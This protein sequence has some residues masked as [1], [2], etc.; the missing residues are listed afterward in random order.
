LGG[1][2]LRS[3]K[4]TL[5]L[6]TK[7]IQADVRLNN[8]DVVKDDMA[9]IFAVNHFTRLE[10]IL[11]PYFLYKQFGTEVWSLA[12][13]ELFEGR[14][15]KFLLSTGNVSTRDP[16]RD[17]VIIHS[18]LKGEHP[19]IIFPEGAM[20]KDKKVIDHRGEFR[21]YNNGKRR[22][23]HTGAA[24]LALRAEFYR[25]KLACF[26]N[27]P[28]H[29]GDREAVLERFNLESL[30]EV[31]AKR[32]VIVPVNV[33][34]FPIRARENVFLRMARG[35]AK[36]DLSP[37]A[38][39][40][41]SV[42]GTLIA[43]D[44]DIDVTFGDPIDVRDHLFTRETSELLA[45][46][47]HDMDALEADAGSLFN[48][49]ARTLMMRYMRDI[50]DLTTVNYDHIFGTILRYQRQRRFTERSYRNR[51][52]LAA[53][54]LA[55]TGKYEMHDLL[56]KNYREIIYEDM[57]PKFH[58]FMGVCLREGIV[59]ADGDHYVKNF[60]HRKSTADFH[61]S[62][63]EALSNVIANEIEPLADLAASIKHVAHMPREALSR[64][65]RE[66]FLEEDAIAF[67][68]DYKAFARPGESKPMDV[69]RPFLL[70]P[71]RVKGGILLVHGYMAAPLEIRAMAD[72]FFDHGYAVYGVRLK[73]HGTAPEDLAQT[74][75]TEWYE[76]LNRGYAVIKSVTD[77]ITIGGFSTG[78]VLALLAAARKGSKVQAAFSICAPL[79]L[80]NYMARHASSVVRMNAVLS[81]LGRNPK[82][83]IEN[84][85]ENDHI[86]YRRNPI[87]G[88]R[89][90]GEA[91]KA[92]EAELGNVH[93][94][95]LIVQSHKDPVVDPISG[96]TIFDK[97]G[98]E[99]KELTV[100]NRSNHGIINGEG[101]EEV[102]DRVHRFLHWARAKHRQP[103]LL[104][105]TQAAEAS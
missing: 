35:I 30:E 6:A 25:Q 76:S 95:S 68:Q 97:L 28:N 10:T 52:F 33:T 21:V 56:E 27:D 96:P 14:I 11:L 45:C 20:I 4:W 104:E 34:Y 87:V 16:D 7:L 40:E 1:F 62:R 58:D 5:E 57:S 72:Y 24:V 26:H 8:A 53:H 83:F 22:P 3:T 9:I 64:R 69:G 99:D 80:R 15:G 73:G 65:I 47:D 79:Q 29:D 100:F 39:E 81:K 86:N 82:E 38:V 23:P 42:E 17:K 88:V 77:F 94:P 12:A 75:W 2:A 78:G 55:E 19:W 51:I 18:L 49:S 85:P 50:Y 59:T 93:V 102:F 91:M 101:S 103:V 41:L 60:G 13:G 44:T 105:A 70:T 32:T 54:A 89:E 90:L 36:K 74:E 46:G 48:D 84:D 98:T 71:S 37:R 43:K 92:M 66:I 31:I 67:D 63:K 61:V